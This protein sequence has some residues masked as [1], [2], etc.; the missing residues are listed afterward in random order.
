MIVGNSPQRLPLLNDESAAQCIHGFY[1]V[2]STVRKN[3]LVNSSLNSSDNPTTVYDE[4]YSTY[5]FDISPFGYNRDYIIWRKSKINQIVI[6]YVKEGKVLDDGGGYGFLNEFLDNQKCEYYNMDCS[7]EMLRY[8]TSK[9]RCIGVGE[10][11]PFKDESFDTVVSGDVLEHTQ[12]KVQYL[13]EAYRVLKQGGVFI[14]N[15]PR[16]GWRATYRTSVWFWIPIL[17]NV[18]VRL[19]N[20]VVKKDARTKSLD[21]LDVPSDE[22]WLKT[23]FE[24]LGYEIIVQSRTDNHL[25][26][27]THV[28]WRKF[29]DLFVDPKKF[30]HCAFY[31][32]KKK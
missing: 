11:L 20:Y 29:A 14:L 23:Q 17:S 6:S 30:G 10:A 16:T 2:T 9:K 4:L 22:A 24:A 26:A 5:N 28:F 1:L 18:Y 19:K 21:V 3:Y 25:F 27:F 15:T 7:L 12:D 32:C 13:K 8:D 31:V